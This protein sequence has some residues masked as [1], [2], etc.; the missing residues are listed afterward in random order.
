[1]FA[2]V[3]RWVAGFTDDDNSKPADAQFLNA[4]ESALL[5]LLGEEPTADYIPAWDGGLLR[6]HFQKLLNKHI[7]PAA[8]IA[9]SK[10]DF[11]GGLVDADISATAA[12]AA[13]KISGLGAYTLPS[14]V[15][16]D[17]AGGVVPSGWLACDGSAVSRTTY[18]ALFAAIGTTHGS[19]DG[20]T[21]FNLPDSRD[22]VSIGAGG[23]TALGVTDGVA[24]ANRHATRHRHSPH[25]HTYTDPGSADGTG[26]LGGV[27]GPN[28]PGTH[29]G[30]ADGGS[31]IG[32]D[33][34]DGSAF[35]AFNKIIKT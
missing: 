23:N 15:V 6:F 19:G 10:L 2:Y 28:A 13:S 22:R 18:A 25:Y 5:V 24:A 3:K 31:G 12:I 30:T 8:A 9:R 7:D 35:I 16:V 27:S 20:S 4:V 32:T 26:G 33:P 29:T 14:G 17:Y 11:G 21:T 34:L 1:M